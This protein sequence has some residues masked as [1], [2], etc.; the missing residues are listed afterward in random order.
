M[1]ASCSASR[2]AADSSSSPVGVLDPAGRE[3]HRRLVGVLVEGNRLVGDVIAVR[4][5]QHQ[6]WVCTTIPA[7]RP[8]SVSGVRSN[9][10]TSHPMSRNASGAVRPTSEP[11]TMMTRGPSVVSSGVGLASVGARVAEVEVFGVEDRFVEQRGDVVVVERVDD[12]SS[13]AL[14]GDEPEV[15]KGPQLV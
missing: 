3:R 12:L 5:E 10:S 2:D 8:S 11:P 14:A 6:Q 9:T 4:A 7:P 13:G 15:A 1:I